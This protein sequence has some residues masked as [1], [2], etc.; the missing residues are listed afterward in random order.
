[1]LLK[2][3]KTHA[4]FV[5]TRTMLW[6]AIISYSAF[7]VG[8][9]TYEN[10]QLSKDIEKKKQEIQELKEIKKNMQLSLIFYQS[11][12]FKEIEARRR[13]NLKGPGEHVVALPQFKTEPTLSIVAPSFTD[14]SKSSLLP[15]YLAW[16]NLFVK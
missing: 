3:L 1:M 8:H 6:V 4:P 12:S 5:L 9:S 10:Y 11:N 16:W 7:L 15:P 2:P 13:L 14:Q